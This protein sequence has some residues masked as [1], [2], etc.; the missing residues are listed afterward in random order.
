MQFQSFLYEV[1]KILIKLFF[2]W[3]YRKNCLLKKREIII[4]TDKIFLIIELI[5]NLIN[6]NY[7]S[8]TQ[9]AN[10]QGYKNN[11]LND[12]PTFNTDRIKRRSIIHYSYI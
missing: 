1:C 2:T 4:K 6:F 7:N 12:A 9:F 11:W 8:S 10:L 5:Q 3:E